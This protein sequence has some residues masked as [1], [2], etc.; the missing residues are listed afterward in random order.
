MLRAIPYF[1]WGNRG[2]NQMRVWMHEK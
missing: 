2:L 1:A